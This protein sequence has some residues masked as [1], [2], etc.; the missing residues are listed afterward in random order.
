VAIHPFDDGAAEALPVLETA[1]RQTVDSIRRDLL[2]PK[3]QLLW[4]EST[5]RR[6]HSLA[7][8][9]HECV[10][11]DHLSEIATANESSD[12]MGLTARHH[13]ETWIVG[14]YLLVC[15][16]SMTTLRGEDSRAQRA[17]EAD[18]RRLQQEGLLADLDV[19][20]MFEQSNRDPRRLQYETIFREVDRVLN[21]LGLIVNTRVLYGWVYR[22]L[23]A[24]LG[25]H[26]TLRVLDRYVDSNS[27]FFA[28][29]D[30]RPLDTNFRRRP[31][32][33]AIVLTCIHALMALG[34]L[35]VPSQ[36]YG[37]TVSRLGMN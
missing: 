16:D 3:C 21:Q 27:G 33:F 25:G 15:D 17:A 35:G 7:A 22:S 31:M 18:I 9:S 20:Q 34:G 24:N 23:S 1:L 30:A 12:L 10:V 4:C 19:D 28:R 2:S 37:D 29:V 13:L 11:L 14:I 32:Q 6:I 36:N 26:P 5:W 8:L